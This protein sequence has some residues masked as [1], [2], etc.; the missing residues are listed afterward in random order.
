MAYRLIRRIGGKGLAPV[1]F[2]EALRGV[3]VAAGRVYAVGDSALKVFGP[4]GELASQWAT[5]RPGECVAV[6]G[7]GRAW[8]GEW[9]QIEIFEAKQGLVA[10]WR[11][12]ERL[13]R[14][15]AIGFAGSDVFVADALRGAS[16]A[17]TPSATS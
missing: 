15:T 13:G 4:D 1:Q 12:P 11:D 5:S 2:R 17:T 9:K 16:A 14:V 10:T 6:D 7:A 3:A 8:V